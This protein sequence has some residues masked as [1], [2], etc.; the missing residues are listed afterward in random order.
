[1]SVKKIIS[2]FKIPPIKQQSEVQDILSDS[3]IEESFESEANFLSKSIYHKILSEIINPTSEFPYYLGWIVGIEEIIKDCKLNPKKVAAIGLKFQKILSLEIEQDTIQRM[4]NGE[5]ADHIEQKG[6]TYFDL[7]PEEFT[8]SSCNKTF[9]WGKVKRTLD[10][11]NINVVPTVCKIWNHYSLIDN[12]ATIGK[13]LDDPFQYKP[14]N[15]KANFYYPIN[16]VTTSIGNHSANVGLYESG[17][18]IQNLNVYDITDW[19]EEVSFDAQEEAFIHLTCDQKLI[20][21]KIFHENIG[22][23]YEIGKL[24]YNNNV[25]LSIEDIKSMN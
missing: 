14:D 10:A 23:I 1:M 2:Y 9:K 15:S 19:F 3:D 13:V 8:C 22:H 12:F 17:S 4:L 25:Q 5:N 24:L 11:V 6:G 20:P 7:F 16:L 18:V 21:E